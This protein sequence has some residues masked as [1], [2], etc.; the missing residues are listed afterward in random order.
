MD[1]PKHNHRNT[2]QY[3]SNLLCSNKSDMDRK[4]LSLI[5][6]ATN[7]DLL[8]LIKSFKNEINVNNQKNNLQ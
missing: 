1:A 4:L 2:I 6:P 7:R 8:Y 5:K 3:D